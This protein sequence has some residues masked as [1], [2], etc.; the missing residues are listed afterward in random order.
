[1]YAFAS[2]E[3]TFF[4]PY[5]VMAIST[6]ETVFQ[7]LKQWKS[8]TYCLLNQRELHLQSKSFQQWLFIGLKKQVQGLVVF[9][10]QNCPKPTWLSALEILLL[11]WACCWW[12]SKS[13]E[14]VSD[15]LRGVLKLKRISCGYLFMACNYAQGTLSFWRIGFF[16]LRST[17]C[18]LSIL[19]SRI[20]LAFRDT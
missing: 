14:S 5:F 8:W 13:M 20:L 19:G 16:I 12:A 10:R 15:R 18:A 4:R 1:M 17:S 9:E 6:K 2:F 3:L 11:V 7:N